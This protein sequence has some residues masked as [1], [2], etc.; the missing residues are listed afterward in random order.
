MHRWSQIPAIYINSY[1]DGNGG[2]DADL[3]GSS[4]T[5]STWEEHGK[6]VHMGL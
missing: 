3:G 1:C 4:E 6:L 2:F 5:G